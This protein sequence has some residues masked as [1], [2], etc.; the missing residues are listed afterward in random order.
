[1][2]IYIIP[3]DNIALSSVETRSLVPTGEWQLS[4]ITID[5]LPGEQPAVWAKIYDTR[6]N[7][8]IR[9]ARLTQPSPFEFLPLLQISGFT[10]S[11]NCLPVEVSDLVVDTWR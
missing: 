7:A 3:L 6:T 5:F 10:R 4:N 2:A 8:L 9:K 1:M 11:D